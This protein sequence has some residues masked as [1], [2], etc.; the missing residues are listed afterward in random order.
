M[1]VRWATYYDIKQNLFQ[2]WEYFLHAKSCDQSYREFTTARIIFDITNSQNI[3]LPEYTLLL[4]YSVGNYL[5]YVQSAW[6]AIKILNFTKLFFKHSWKFKE[7]LDS[8]FPY[9]PYLCSDITHTFIAEC[10]TAEGEF[11]SVLPKAQLNDCPVDSMYSCK[12]DGFLEPPC[13]LQ[14]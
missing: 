3:I 14:N 9:F 6:Q 13:S 4:R 11:P 8:E 10:V 12:R 5:C 7:A 1:C 2:I